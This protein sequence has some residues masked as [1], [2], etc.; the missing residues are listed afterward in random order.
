MQAVVLAGGRGSRLAA[1]AAAPPKPLVELN[2]MSALDHAL[3]Q[4]AAAGVDEVLVLTGW[5]A[6]ELARAVGD[7][8][9]FG[10]RARCIAEPSPLGTAGAVRAVRDQLRETFVVVY[11]DV[12]FA[13]ELEAMI[14]LHRRSGAWATLAAHPNDHPFD[15]DRIVADRQ[16]RIERIVRARANAEPDDGALC[17]AALYVMERRLVDEIPAD[18][19]HDFARDVFPA[20]LARG[21]PL[22]VWRTA[23]YLK[24][25]GTVERRDKVS[26]ALARGIPERLRRRTPKP[27]LVCDRDGVLVEDRPYISRGDELR[28]LPGAARA[29][30]R[31]NDAAVLAVCCTNQPVV[32]RGELDED[33]LHA[34]HRRLE[35]LLGGDGAWLD[36]IF[37]C[38]HHPDRGFSGERAELKIACACRKPQP[39]MI[40]AAEAALGLDRARS[41]VVGDRTADL[42]CARNAGMIGVGV[43]T[44]AAC[45]DGRYPIAPETPLLPALAD[46]VALMLDTAPS[47]SRI[48]DAAP[49]ARVFVVG[50][51]SRAGKTVA[52]AALRL[53]LQARGRDVLHLSLDRFIQPAATRRP[54][55]RLRERLRHADAAAALARLVGG[56]T[57]LL[58][59]YDPFTRAAAPAMTATLPPGRVLV[60][61]GLLATALELPG[62]LRVAVEAPAEA[63]LARRRA[64]YAWKGLAGD[65]LE[66]AVSG[67]PGDDEDEAVVA[68]L[69]RADVR[70]RLAPSLALEEIR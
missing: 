4:L 25:M 28:L 53:A 47:W 14:A 48:L 1:D 61:D 34:L 62:A 24:D 10:L 43:L 21:R 42:A 16:G 44:G 63:R 12:V 55:A 27:A 54:E 9:R 15:S 57:L 51:A 65:A 39:G 26:Q 41:L 59:S 5:R 17:S 31:L 32:A 69:A 3:A 70:V 7:G 36:A 38:P 67:A 18:G 30:G 22:Q 35:G 19:A 60:V 50:G 37:H 11:A 40:Y 20:L 29:L 33:G 56:Q 23:E 68:A 13:V 8:A 2:G 52:A 64:F 6:D 46:A 45:R 49:A 58:P 66:L